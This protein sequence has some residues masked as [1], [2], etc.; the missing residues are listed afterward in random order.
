MQ[1]RV[2]D[3]RLA[4]GIVVVPAKLRKGKK[5]PMVYPLWSDVREM[6]RAMMP[7][8]LPARELVWP[9]PRDKT[10]FYYWYGKMLRM[11]GLPDGRANKPHAMRVSHASWTHLA[12]GDATRALGHG[13][14]ETTRKSYLDSTL[15]KPDERQLFRPW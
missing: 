8:Q 10:T 7:P 4:D 5:R 1:L 2:E 6:M 9:W 11:A 15:I 12:G 13:S 3:V 14:P